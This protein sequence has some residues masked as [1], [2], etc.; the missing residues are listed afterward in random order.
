VLLLL[1]VA[2]PVVV[3]IGEHTNHP[4]DALLQA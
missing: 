1:L 3:V 4:I 2:V